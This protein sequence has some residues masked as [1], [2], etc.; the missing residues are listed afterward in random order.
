MHMWFMP[1]TVASSTARRSARARSVARA[2]RRR[3]LSRIRSQSA[4]ARRERVV[5]R[6]RKLRNTAITRRSM[7]T[8]EIPQ[9]NAKSATTRVGMA[10]DRITRHRCRILSCSIPY[11]LTAVLGSMNTLPDSQVQARRVAFRYPGP[12]RSSSTHS[13]VMVEFWLNSHYLNVE[14]L[15]ARTYGQIPPSLPFSHYR[16]AERARRFGRHDRLAKHLHK[17]IDTSG[18]VPRLADAA[19]SELECGAACS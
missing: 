18:P 8:K 11:M 9:S 12:Q 2:V 10:N 17:V 4:T 19:V 14:P 6:S 16:F 3:A 5:R 15:V 13:T 7:S 1:R